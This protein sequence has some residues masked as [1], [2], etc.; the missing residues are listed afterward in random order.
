MI[1]A[2]ATPLEA[3]GVVFLLFWNL[4]VTYCLQSRLFC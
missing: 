3:N 4:F 2:V 1:C